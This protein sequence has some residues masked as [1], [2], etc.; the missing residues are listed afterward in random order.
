M[1]AP[2]RWV[3]AGLSSAA[4]LAAVA[5]AWQALQPPSP[6]Q[7]EKKIQALERQ[8]SV[9][10]AG[11]LTGWAEC[12][13]LAMQFGPEKARWCFDASNKQAELD[14]QAYQAA[15]EKIDELRTQLP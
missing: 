14:A 8:Q 6:A 11:A 4:T 13:S 10:A 12:Q 3:V 1:A 7:I 5:L 9:R 15:Q 2:S